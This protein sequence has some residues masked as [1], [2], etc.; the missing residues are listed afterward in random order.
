MLYTRGKSPDD[1]DSMGLPV[2]V[3]VNLVLLRVFLIFVGACAGDDVS[4]V[5][6]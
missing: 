6:H 2:L 4:D 1:T 5:G 3:S